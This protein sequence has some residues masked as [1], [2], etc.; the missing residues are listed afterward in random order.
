VALVVAI[1]AGVIVWLLLSGREPESA[2]PGGD[3]QAS[4]TPPTSPS[5]EPSP[6]AADME[7][8]IA[9]YLATATTDPNASFQMLTPQ[10]QRESGGIEGYRGFWDTVESAELQSINADPQ[11][12]T[13]DYT[14]EYVIDSSGPG[15]GGE[16]TD[17]VRLALVFEDGTYKIAGES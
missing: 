9:T 8:F 12:L 10:F 1:L 6:T 11:A 16:S 7:D 5:A 14:V 2:N 3:G 17:D 13:V 4:S 15:S